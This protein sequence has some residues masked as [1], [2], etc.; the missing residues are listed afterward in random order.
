MTDRTVRGFGK[1]GTSFSKV[2]SPVIVIL[3]VILSLSIIARIILLSKTVAKV[4]IK[5]L[6][7]KYILVYVGSGAGKPL[8]MCLIL[9]GYTRDD[10]I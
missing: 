2:C 1:V 3:E 8:S 9:S 6:S 4:A 5:K 10:A 7:R